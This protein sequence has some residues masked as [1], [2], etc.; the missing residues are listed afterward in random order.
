MTRLAAAVTGA[1]GTVEHAAIAFHN[2]TAAIK[3]TA[4]SGEDVKSAIT[5]MV[6]IFSKGRVSAEELS[7][8]L[9]E[10]FPGAVTKF[11]EANSDIYKSTA[12][13]QD[14]LKKGEVGLKQLWEFVMLL[15]DEY[16]DTA[17]KIGASD[18]EAGARAVV[19]MN[20]LRIHLG[21]LLKPIGAQFQVIQAQILEDI[22][23]AIVKM[24]EWAVKVGQIAVTVIKFVQKNF[25]DLRDTI[26]IFGGG[27]LLGTLMQS[28]ATV[29]AG[30]IT[31]TKVINGIRNAMVALNI[32]SFANPWVALAAGIIA[33]AVAVDRFLNG[34]KKLQE[35]AAS[36]DFGAIAQAK[37][38]VED[39]KKTNEKLAN[40]FDEN[41]KNNLKTTPRPGSE[42]YE[43]ALET[44]KKKIEA[45]KDLIKELLKA[46]EDGN[47]ANNQAQKDLIENLKKGL[48]P[49]PGFGG[50]E[51]GDGD[52]VYKG[53]SGGIKKF[54]DDVKN[55]TEEV[56]NVTA[57]WFDRM[58][59]SLTNFVMTGKLKFKEFARSIIADIAKMIAKQMIFNMIA[60]LGNWGSLAADRRF[61][62][63]GKG[64]ALNSPIGDLPKGANGLV[65]AKNGIV[66]YAK[67]GIV[68][69]PTLFPFAKGVGLMGEAGPE[70]IVPLKRGRDGKLGI[71]GGGGAT[72]VN[73]SVDAKG[74]KVE[75]DGKQ[76]AQLGRM[77]G[78]AI[79]MELAKQKRPGG[80]LA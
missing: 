45:N 37:K 42:M 54:S 53:F 52:G 36:G 64:S 1:G 3:G 5:A 6:Q 50:G 26:L 39:L 31:L 14:A 20:A 79:E 56:A 70:A 51:G 69:S 32:A 71:A 62:G 75:G 35:K 4:G 65:V 15:G 77:L 12:D 48:E 46:I 57:S 7:G 22:I 16:T 29:I 33:A 28:I 34:T 38:M 47:A 67:G 55:M 9:G 80:L 58:A 74:T 21:Q 63:L 40:Q 23:P 10:R 49:L 78:S 17:A 59:D 43:E 41:F 68:N 2:V 61:S 72:T 60:G 24:G 25:D 19:Q 76:M 11:Q 30:G 44:Y 73:V 27:L 13:L 8:Q 18:E 66:P